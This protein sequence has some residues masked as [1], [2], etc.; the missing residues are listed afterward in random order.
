M[1]VNISGDVDLTKVI[2][3]QLE[4]I[5]QDFKIFFKHHFKIES[6]PTF[7]PSFQ[8]HKISFPIKSTLILLDLDINEKLE[9][10]LD[11]LERYS[12]PKAEILKLKILEL[13]EKR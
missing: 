1:V 3:E 2:I 9:Y 5:S 12:D 13:L 10:Y 8:K 4:K 7:I 6:K 11:D